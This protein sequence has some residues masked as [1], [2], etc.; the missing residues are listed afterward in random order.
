MLMNAPHSLVK[1]NHY[2]VVAGNGKRERV[3]FGT[4]LPLS[5]RAAS[6]YAKS[7]SGDTRVIMRKTAARSGLI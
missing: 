1:P 7:L 5:K 6:S 4:F 3:V 2:V